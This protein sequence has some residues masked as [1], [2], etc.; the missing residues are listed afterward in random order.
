MCFYVL[1]YIL[2]VF[3]QI[4]DNLT[5]KNILMHAEGKKATPASK[6]ADNETER[7]GCYTSILSVKAI[8]MYSI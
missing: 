2:I 5:R 8:N 7:R 6:A 3:K 1:V 4:D